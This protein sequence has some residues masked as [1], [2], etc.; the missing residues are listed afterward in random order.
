MSKVYEEEMSI[1]KDTV[2]KKEH[3]YKQFFEEYPDKTELEPP[4]IYTWST[5]NIHLQF[6]GWEI[7]LCTDGTYYLNDTTG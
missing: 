6:H 5:G 3:P 2:E 7:V 1:Y 4:K